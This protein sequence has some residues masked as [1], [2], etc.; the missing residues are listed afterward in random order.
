MKTDDWRRPPP[1]I[2]AGELFSSWL[3]QAWTAT[4]GRGAPDAPVVRLSLSG[5]GGGEWELRASDETLEIEP[6]PAGQ[7]ARGSEPGVWIRQP[8][9]DFLAAL[10][11]D[12]DLPQLLPPSW[13]VLDL[14][15][16]DP[17]DVE[18]VRRIDGRIAIEIQGKRRRRWTLDA[19]F[20][21][22]GV[23]AGRPRST[24][25]IDGA[26]YDAV[27]TGS[28]APLQAL[29]EGKVKLEGDRTLAMQALMLVGARLAR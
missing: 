14:L 12:G 16:M 1:G 24:V 27:R 19:A 23:S 22:A 10:H 17:R 25:R 11:G 6:V 5:A 21:K 4:G 15:F 2:T 7:R 9:L 28:V 13:S 8:V 29:L 20:G 26:T 3:P 18:L